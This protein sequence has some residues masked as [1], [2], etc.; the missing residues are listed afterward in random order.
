MGWWFFAT[1]SPHNRGWLP[2]L[3]LAFFLCSGFISSSTFVL[4]LVDRLI[5]SHGFS[6]SSLF[7]S[8][9]FCYASK[10]LKVY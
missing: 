4:R 10:I 5:L 6:H 2:W 1:A 8:R 3:Q 7:S 9:V